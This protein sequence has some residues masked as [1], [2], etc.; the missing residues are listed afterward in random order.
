MSILYHAFLV[1]SIGKSRLAQ[2]LFLWERKGDYTLTK[3]AFHGIL[4]DDGS[5]RFLLGKNNPLNGDG[6]EKDYALSKEYRERAF[7]RAVS[8]SYL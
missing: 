6:K 7:Q 2:F 5:Q 4:L 8:K 1:S 3:S